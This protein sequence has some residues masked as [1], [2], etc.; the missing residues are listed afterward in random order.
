MSMSILQKLN[1]IKT[2]KIGKFPVVIL[3]L[4]YFEN[5]K[6]D[7]GMYQS[8]TFRKEVIKARAEVKK[9]EFL[10]FEEVNKK[11]KLK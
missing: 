4:D 8:K 3:P 7:L 10:T 5:I 6:E 9:G 1:R 2:Q 11:L